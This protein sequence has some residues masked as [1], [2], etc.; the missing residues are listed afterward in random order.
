MENVNFL[1]NNNYDQPSAEDDQPRNIE[2]IDPVAFADFISRN[3]W[4]EL[5]RDKF[6]KL[7]IA[8][9]FEIK[10]SAKVFE[11]D[12]KGRIVNLKTNAE[13]IFGIADPGSPMSFSNETTARRLY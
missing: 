1:Q 12:L 10:K 2:G 6:F 9:A 4:E 7:A 8:Q 13:I 3:G 11:E 5:R